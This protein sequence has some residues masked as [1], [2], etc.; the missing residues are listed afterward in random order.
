[1]C[2]DRVYV[3][4][5][6]SSPK[7]PIHDTQPTKFTTLYLY[8]DSSYICQSNEGQ[9]GTVLTFVKHVGCSGDTV[10]QENTAF[11]YFIPL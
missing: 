11:Y 3:Y 2:V 9:R 7:E 5:Y 1:M 10:Y 4:K 6:I 8:T